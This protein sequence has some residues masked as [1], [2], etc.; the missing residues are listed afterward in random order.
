V[1]LRGDRGAARR[2]NRANQAFFGD[3]ECRRSFDCS[4]G[5]G[6]TALTS[7]NFDVRHVSKT[8]AETGQVANATAL[9]AAPQI[10][11]A[12]GRGHSRCPDLGLVGSVCMASTA[13][14]SSIL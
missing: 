13:R 7:L 1:A 14:R 11:S 6:V 12:I 10:R 5:G 8:N 2:P 4:D 3:P 9:V